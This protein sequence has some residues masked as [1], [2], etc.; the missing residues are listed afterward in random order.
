[1]D[2]EDED[3]IEC[4]VRQNNIPESTTDGMEDKIRIVHKFKN[5]SK[6]NYANL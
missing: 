3:L 1:M 2:Y 6:K 5:K 4:F